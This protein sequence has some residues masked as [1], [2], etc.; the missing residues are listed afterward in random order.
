MSAQH[1]GFTTFSFHERGFTLVE[2]LVVITIITIL[3]TIGL[4]IYSKAQKQA[5]VAKRVEDLRAIR[6][7]LEIYYA[8]NGVYPSTNGNLSSECA[9]GGSLAP[10]QVIPNLVPTYMA[11]F[12]SDP[13][14]NKTASTSCY[15]YRSDGKDYKLWDM[16]ISEFSSAD[17][18][19]QRNLIDPNLDGVTGGNS[20]CLVDGNSITAWAVYSSCTTSPCSGS[21]VW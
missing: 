16:N 2:L 18:Q 4:T 14:M 11:A 1:K 3:A 9:N 20:S 12:P 21:C 15:I 8:R 7:A 10:D 6:T 17:Y 5:R 13:S 19:S